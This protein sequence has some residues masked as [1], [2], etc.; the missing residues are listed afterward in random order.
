MRDHGVPGFPD[1]DSNG[2]I[3][4]DGNTLGTDPGSDAFKKAEKECKDLVPPESATPSQEDYQAALTYSACMR[5][6]GV[7]DFP[8]PMA[9]G[10]AP[11]SSSDGSGQAGPD[12]SSPK[13]QA[14]QEACKDLMP[15]GAQTGTNGKP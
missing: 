12:P 1:P 4:I 6:N 9:P 2:G 14:A 5:E 7:P 8:D 3:T 15:Q 13:F 11:D 10:S